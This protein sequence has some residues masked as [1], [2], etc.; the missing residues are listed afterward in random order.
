MSY[1][2][3]IINKQKRA[4]FTFIWRGVALAAIGGY[5]AIMILKNGMGTAV[6]TGGGANVLV[7]KLMVWLTERGI[8][9]EQLLPFFMAGLFCIIAAIGIYNVVRGVWLMSPMHTTFGKSVLQQMKNG[10]SASDVI[11]VINADMEQEPYVFGSVHIG[12]KWIADTE[13]MRLEAIR[14]VFWFDQAMEDYVL[15]CV[16]EAQNLWAASLRNRDDRDKAAKHLQKNLPDVAHGDKEAYIAFVSGE[17]I[18][19]EQP[20]E[21]ITLQQNAKFSFVAADGTPT[22]NFTLETAC[23]ALRALENSGTIALRVLTPGMVSEVSFVREGSGWNV[24]VIYQ[25]ENEER[26]AVQTVDK[27]KAE[28]ILESVIKQNLLPDFYGKAK[29]SR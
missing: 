15:C 20:V 23:Q 16:D 19:Q 18:V 8:N 11:D 2:S 24:G 28:S 9:A 14:G 27:N 22:S 26:R 5:A 13:A 7:R 4:Y 6:Q 25:E 3:Q 10:E 17:P 29:A 12:R 21:K 1:V